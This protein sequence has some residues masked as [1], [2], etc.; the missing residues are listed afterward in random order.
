MPGPT[1]NER[2]AMAPLPEVALQ[3]T[4][5]TQSTVAVFPH[6]LIGVTLRA[7]VGGEDHDR[8]V[9]EAARGECGEHGADRGVGLGHEVTEAVGAGSPHELLR[10]HDRGV[11]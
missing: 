2:H 10:R 9:G 7:V 8:I 11:G 6:S 3:A 1:D 4:E 5:R